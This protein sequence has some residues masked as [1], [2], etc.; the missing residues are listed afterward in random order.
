MAEKRQVPPDWRNATTVD[1]PTAGALLGGLSR[2]TAYRAALRG[3][4]P[5]IVIGARKV[6]P[7]AKLR[8]MLGE[9]PDAG[10][11]S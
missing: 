10:S 8:R 2:T 6:V 11:G 7:V 5:V 9:L 1:V 4:I 3:E